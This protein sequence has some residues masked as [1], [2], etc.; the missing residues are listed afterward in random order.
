MI[1]RSALDAAHPTIVRYLG[2]LLATVL[3]L[4]PLVTSVDAAEVAG[5]YVLATG[6]VFY[7]SIRG[8]GN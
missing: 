1:S 4:A 5:A 8:N 2:L 3:V 6:M 7:K